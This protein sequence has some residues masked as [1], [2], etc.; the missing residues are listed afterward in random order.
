[1]TN[2]IKDTMDDRGITIEELVEASM[3]SKQSITAFYNGRRKPGKKAQT[4]LLK[5]LDYD[6]DDIYYEDSAK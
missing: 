5:L 6:E 2:W 3:L 1:M 4:N